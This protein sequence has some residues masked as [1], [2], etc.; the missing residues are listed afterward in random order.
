M[1]VCISTVV[2]PDR[3]RLVLR[4]EVEPGMLGMICDGVVSLSDLGPVEIDLDQLVT[5]DGGGAMV[6]VADLL[7]EQVRDGH[8][9][10]REPGVPD[11]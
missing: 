1:S 3:I 5:P 2:E 10:L 11:G 7:A 8:V 6:V 4:G 9:V